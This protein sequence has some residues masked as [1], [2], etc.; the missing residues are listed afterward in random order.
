MPD[1]KVKGM[2]TTQQGRVVYDR[3][4]H[5]FSFRDFFRIG[6]KINLRFWL[7][8]ANKWLGL[9]GILDDA[10]GPDQPLGRMPT[11]MVDWD[12]YSRTRMRTLTIEALGAGEF[13]TKSDIA[14]IFVNQEVKEKLDG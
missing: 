10:F 5:K 6:K 9:L 4:K 1:A 2:I 3:K 11:E 14:I 8:P 7:I 12:V 13:A